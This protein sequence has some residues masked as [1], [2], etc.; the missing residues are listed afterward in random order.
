MRGQAQVTEK[1]KFIII[2]HDMDSYRTFSLNYYRSLKVKTSFLILLRPSLLRFG[3][4]NVH[5][6]ET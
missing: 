1:I 5:C 6:T 3:A 2:G 4:P